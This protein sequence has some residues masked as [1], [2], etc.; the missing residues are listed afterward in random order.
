M[1]RTVEDVQHRE[2]EVICRSSQDKA[3]ISD[4]S[5]TSEGPS[6][7]LRLCSTVMLQAIRPSNRRCRDVIDG[8]GGEAKSSGG[9]GVPGV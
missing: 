2:S 7:P 6:Q 8:E 5:T 1:N 3:V 9:G 4:K